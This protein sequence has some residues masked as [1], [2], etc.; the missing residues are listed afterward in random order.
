MLEQKINL[1]SRNLVVSRMPHP[2]ILETVGGDRISLKQE[3]RKTETEIS[4]VEIFSK[5]P[6]K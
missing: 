6:L 4:T 5:K 1:F 2:D 3:L